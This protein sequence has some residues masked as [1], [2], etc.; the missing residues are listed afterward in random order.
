MQRRDFNSLI[1]LSSLGFISYA[2]PISDKIKI[3]KKHNLNH[4]YPNQLG[5]LKQQE[6]K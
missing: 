5:K 3:I 4:N 1:G 2:N 6:G